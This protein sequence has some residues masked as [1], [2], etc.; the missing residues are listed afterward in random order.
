MKTTALVLPILAGA[1]ILALSGTVSARVKL[2]ALVG[3]NMVVQRGEKARIWGWADAGERVTVSMNGKSETTTAGADGKW[4]VRLGPFSAGGPYDMT[5]AGTDTI[6]VKNV[7]VGEV[8]VGSG[9]SN[10]EFVLQNSANGAADIAAADFPTIRLFTVTKATSMTPK[11]DVD[12]HWDVCSPAT[13]GSFS[14]V[15]FYFGREL[16]R[17]LKVPVGLIHTSWGGTPAEAW[18]SR[19][20]LES[21]P[22]FRPLVD[23]L[24]ASLKGEPEAMKAYHE[25]QAKW[26]AEHLLQDTE[27]KGVGL[28]YAG[29]DFDASDWKTMA[30]PQL[31]ET[32]GLQID[33]SVWFRREV[34]V[35]ADWAGKDLV[36]TL[37]ALD[38]Y[39]TTYVNGT[40]VGATGAETPQYWSAMRRY[41]V[42][43]ALVRAGRNVVAVRVFDHGGNGGFSG[44]ASK[45]G[46]GPEGAAPMSLVGD[47]RYKVETGVAPIEVDWGSQPIAP[48][49][50]GNPNSPTVLFNAMLAPLTPYTIRGAIWYQGEA[51]VDRA[52]QYRTLFPAM[53]RDW[54]RA[55]GEPD[56]PFFFVQLANFMDRKPEP[57]ESHWAE[58]REAQTMTLA[59]PNTGMATIIDIGEASDI[60][61]KNKHD[62]G[63]RLALWA[64]AKTYGVGGEYSGPMFESM[65]A[66]E[67]GLLRL[68][69]SHAS[70]L[71][72]SDGRPVKGFEVAG[73]DGKFV[74]A[75]ARIEDGTIIVSNDAIETPVAVRYAWADNPATN[76]YNGA[77][78]PA[79]PF[80]TDTPKR[81]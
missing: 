17:T 13:A 25:A 18:T 28:G 60:H 8:W 14:A 72:T 68:R 26:E 31:F 66:E 56:F 49:G 51:N 6:T 59:E 70:G 63:R 81:P 1:A 41:V 24:D 16:N 73:A 67:N 64:L 5:I 23:A 2:P 38:D 21:D 11:D 4:E 80:R 12:G 65:K 10:M 27:N 48:P 77:G 61:P 39:D 15:A 43:G 62:V 30:I 53:I 7:L 69:F 36:L 35:P 34:E 75:N 3:D 55:W 45:L 22:A 46:I 47:W 50:A 40:Q 19:A 71:R 42:P 78:L 58:L 33:G 76:L 79:V 44:P 54:R 57:S 9:Q 74:W 20:G 29:A 37:G 32:A 52:A